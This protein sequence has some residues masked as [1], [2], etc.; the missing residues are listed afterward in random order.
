MT[1]PFTSGQLNDV[2][3]S[4]T[5]LDLNG[6][7]IAGV[8][9]GSQAPMEQRLGDL[10]LPVGEKTT[11]TEF[12]TALRGAKVE[13]RN[14]TSVLTGRLLSVERKTRAGGGT[15]LEVD[16]V[17]LVTDSGELRTAEVSPS[18]SVKLLEKGSVRSTAIST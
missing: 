1:I 8:S 10:R 17:S 7:R 18:F 14:G 3:N 16:Y 9:Y 15:T 4:L 11:L 12:L 13:I 2:L 5:V 6:G